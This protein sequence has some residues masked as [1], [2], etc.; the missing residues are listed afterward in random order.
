MDNWVHQNR[1]MPD[2]VKIDVEGAELSVLRGGLNVLKNV[3][4]V[5]FEFGGTA[6]DAKNYF[7]DYWN[8]FTGLNFKLYRYTPSG[9]LR[10]ETYSEKEE[11]FEFMNYLAVP[12]KKNSPA[13]R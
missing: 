9:L 12:I 1:V 11:V 2:F 7:R 3:K 4:A 5:Q 10:I 6:I 13:A 8:F